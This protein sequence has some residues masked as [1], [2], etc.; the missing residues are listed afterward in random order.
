MFL[1]ALEVAGLSSDGAPLQVFPYDDSQAS[2]A[3]AFTAAAAAL[4]P[5]DRPL[6]VEPLGLRFLEESILRAALPRAQF[7]G[8]ETVLSDLRAR[9]ERAE[10]DAMRQAID[11]AQRALTATLPL[12]RAG[13]T[14]RELAGELIVQLLRAGS[15]PELAFPPIVG[16]GAGS[17]DPHHV[18]ADKALQPG[19]LV[20]VDWGASVDGYLSDLTRVFAFGDV[21]PDLVR[22]YGVALNANTAAL[23]AVRPGVTCGE[24]D[25]AARAVIEQAGCADM[26]LHRTGHGLGIEAHEP[27]WIRSDNRQP[28]ETGMTFTIEPGVYLA[29]RGGVRVEDDVAVTSAGCELLTSY[30]RELS[31]LG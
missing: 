7:S 3:Q 17:A 11:V 27:P 10:L 31:R 2:R 20:L 4:P 13:M 6:A 24:I 25:Q 8:G 23:A 28:L 16:F 26:I 14:E 19:E 30:P 21:G 15:A 1:P 29:G 5:S 12:V 18:P 9:K 22:I